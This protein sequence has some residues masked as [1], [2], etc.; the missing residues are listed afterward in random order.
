M[1]KKAKKRIVSVL[2]S[3]FMGLAVFTAPVNAFAATMEEVKTAAKDAGVSDFY[4]S[5]G[6]KNPDDYTSKQYDEMLVYIKNYKN[7]V[8]TYLAKYFGGNP[9]DYSS[10]D[11]SRET[12]ND[13]VNMDIAEKQKY[14]QGLSDSE[15]KSFI[16]TMTNS[17]RN[18]VVKQLSTTEITSILTPLV[19][20]AKTLGYNISIDAITG[21]AIDMTI[22]DANGNIIDSSSVG[23]AV[24]DVGYDYTIPIL[25][26]IGAVIF[27]V[28]GFVIIDKKMKRREQK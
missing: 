21:S 3:A 15:R 17:E 23:A 7:S 24:D 6:L 18:S 16:T 11:T 27:S 2:C 9:D 25:S 13:F 22:R 1:K 8:N 4:I 20:F 26:V 10:G 28:T 5:Q 14:L 12:N 19:D